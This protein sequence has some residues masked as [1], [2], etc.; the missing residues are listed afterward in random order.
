MYPEELLCLPS[1]H[2]WSVYVRQGIWEYLVCK[3]LSVP[4][5]SGDFP[6]GKKKKKVIYIPEQIFQV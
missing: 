6:G 3:L 1:I 5:K 2:T 4:S